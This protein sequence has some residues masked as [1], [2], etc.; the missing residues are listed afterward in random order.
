MRDHH[1]AV[2]PVPVQEGQKQ[3]NT[4]HADLHLVIYGQSNPLFAQTHSA[5]ASLR[6]ERE[7]YLKG[8]STV[9]HFKETDILKPCVGDTSSNNIAAPTQ[10][11]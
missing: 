10:V 2:I 1:L 3:I 9:S 11:D 4:P 5:P 6:T 8:N 7:R